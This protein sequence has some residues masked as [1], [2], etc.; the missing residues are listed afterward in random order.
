MGQDVL[1]LGLGFGAHDC[2]R[3][4]SDAERLRVR[5]RIRFRA[6]VRVRIRLGLGL[7]RWRFGGK[8]EARSWELGAGSWGWSPKLAGLQNT[9]I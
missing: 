6:R 1:G 2:F 3:V 5:V 4:F 7:V 9:A 8:W